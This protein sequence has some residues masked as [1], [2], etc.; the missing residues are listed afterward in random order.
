[1]TETTTRHVH[2]GLVEK[3]TSPLASR[4]LLETEH[5][6]NLGIDVAA[7]VPLLNVCFRNP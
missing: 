7:R 2:V 1:M 4:V 6:V 3:V 5:L